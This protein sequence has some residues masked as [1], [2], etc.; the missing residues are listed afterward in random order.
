MLERN[1]DVII[2]GG[3]VAGAGLAIH[4]AQAGRKVAILD[5]A[6]FPSGTTSTHVIY[7]KTIANLDRLGVLDRIL[8]HRPPPLYTAW[9]HQNRMFVAP[10][11][12]EGGRD[13][14]SVFVE[15]LWTPIYSTGRKSRG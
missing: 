10:H 2:V 8:A 9:H 3:R 13:G 15:S 6:T 1:L 14:Q 5:R 4:L 12:M 11:S 7:P